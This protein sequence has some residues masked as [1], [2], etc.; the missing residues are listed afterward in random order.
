ML[1]DSIR[2]PQRAYTIIFT[3]DGLLDFIMI[4]FTETD[5]YE[6]EVEYAVGIC[7]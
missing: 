6:W 5:K 7:Q 3:N 1:K 2:L 4:Y